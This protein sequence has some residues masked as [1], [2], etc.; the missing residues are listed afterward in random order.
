MVCQNVAYH[1][2]RVSLMRPGESVPLTYESKGVKSRRDHGVIVFRG[3][4]GILESGDRTD[5]KGRG[6]HSEKITHAVSPTY[7]RPFL[8]FFNG[9]RRFSSVR[10]TRCRLDRIPLAFQ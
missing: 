7:I 1:F 9:D 3:W 2:I 10:N 8:V 4:A 5:S 6:T